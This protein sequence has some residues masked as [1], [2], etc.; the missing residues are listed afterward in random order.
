MEGD[1]HR[2]SVDNF[3][4]YDLSHKKALAVKLLD[5]LG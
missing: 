1:K 4:E 2:H 3:V 5:L